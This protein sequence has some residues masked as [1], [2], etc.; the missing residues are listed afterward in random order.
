MKRTLIVVAAAVVLLAAALAVFAPAS[1]VAPA[2]V[3]QVLGERGIAAGSA[4]VAW[5]DGRA[6]LTLAAVR[7]DTLI[8]ALDALQRDTGL[9]VVDATLTARVDPGTVRAEILLAR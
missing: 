5:E 4:Q 7:F 9:R 8:A 3:D 6:R 2:V 1:L